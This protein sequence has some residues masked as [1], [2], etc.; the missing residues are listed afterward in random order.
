MKNK[1]LKIILKPM[2]DRNI[3]EL[4]NMIKFYRNCDNREFKYG[5]KVDYFINKKI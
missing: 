4:L 2:G 1:Y 3:G 5:M